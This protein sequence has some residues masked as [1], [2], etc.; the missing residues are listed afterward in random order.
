VKVAVAS[1]SGPEIAALKRLLAEVPAT[2]SWTANNARAVIERWRSDPADVLIVCGSSTLDALALQRDVAGIKIAPIVVVVS[3]PK[4]RV[5]DVYA[6][7]ERGAVDVAATPTLRA[8]G[9]VRDPD[10]LV[11][12]LRGLR[13]SAREA[14]H[15]K[16]TSAA[17]LLLI[18]AS[19]GGPGALAEVLAGLDAGIRARVVVA[20]HIDDEFSP[21]LAGWLAQRS[22]K[23]VELAEDGAVLDTDSVRLVRSDRQP[24]IDAG[25]RVRYRD[26]DAQNPFH[27]CFDTMFESC[28]AA[29][30]LRG[31]AALL[32]GMGADGARGLLALR[33]AG[34]TTL[35]QDAA[36][37]VVF[38]MPRAAAELGA[39]VKVLP[40]D[41][42]AAEAGRALLRLQQGKTG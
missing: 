5:H 14:R 38:G 16:S 11:A 26:L 15:G 28:A 21:G 3:D 2:L 13:T 39:A 41:A 1:D 18:A 8:D 36:S 37:S 29:R 42:I 22:G 17:P 19:T 40:L 27:P 23:R 30:R 35:A 9:S 32:T 7:L 10:R 25:G 6:A 31:V 20:Q 33:Q 34:W 12:K 4:Q 24:T